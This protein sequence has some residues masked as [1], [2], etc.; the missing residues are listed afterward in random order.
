MVAIR[1]VP[2]AARDQRRALSRDHGAILFDVS[3]PVQ[4]R[5]RENGLDEIGDGVRLSGGDHEVV[6]RVRAHDAHHRVHGIRGP[7]PVVDRGQIAQDQ[8]RCASLAD[9]DS[10]ADD[11]LRHEPGFAKRRFVVVQDPRRGVDAGTVTVE[12]AAVNAGRLGDPVDAHRCERGGFVL[13]GRR[14]LAEHEARR[15]VEQARAREVQPNGLQDVEQ[16]F[17]V[18]AVALDVEV[19]APGAPAILSRVMDRSKVVD[20]VGP[21][22]RDEA[23][24]HVAV[25]N[26]RAATE[27]DGLVP[28]GAEAFRQNAAVLTFA[29]DDEGAAHPETISSSG[30]GKMIFPP[31]FRNAASRRTTCS[32]KCQGSTRK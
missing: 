27:A 12:A 32:R 29:P 5:P 1:F 31:A 13:H 3:L 28:L 18:D 7:A 24:D 8:L 20:L 26:V 23:V 25:Q 30:S 22:R 6:R 14:G 21:E 2:E 9:V 15:G 10:A 4:S 11:L 19:A 16:A 17:D